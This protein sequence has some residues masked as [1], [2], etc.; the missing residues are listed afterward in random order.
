MTFKIDLAS[1]MAQVVE[2]LA[3]PHYKRNRDTENE[4]ETIDFQGG[5][6]SAKV[7]LYGSTLKN[8][9][10]Q[11]VKNIHLLSYGYV[12][13]WLNFDPLNI[14]LAKKMDFSWQDVALKEWCHTSSHDSAWRSDGISSPLSTLNFK[15][16]DEIKKLVK[17]NDSSIY[18]YHSLGGIGDRIFEPVFIRTVAVARRQGNAG[19]T[20]HVLVDIKSTKEELTNDAL[21]EILETAEALYHEGSGL[22]F[23]R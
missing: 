6:V 19:W 7:V 14:E 3:N 4:D 2:T 22:G 8:K 18:E 11:V 1:T 17:G 20:D 10:V 9:E 16:Q 5:I 15:M 12:N 13:T 21:P 23:K